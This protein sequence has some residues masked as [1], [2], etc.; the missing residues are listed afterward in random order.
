MV[1]IDAVRVASPCVSLCILNESSV[2]GGCFR[3]IDE[4]RAWSEADDKTRYF[5]IAAA[6]QR[7]SLCV[8]AINEGVFDET[9]A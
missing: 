2:C 9:T 3:S 1:R 5:I 7:Q 4:I 6:R 8:S